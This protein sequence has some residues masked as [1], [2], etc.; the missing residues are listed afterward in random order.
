MT[1]H[2]WPIDANTVPWMGLNA[3]VFG[4]DIFQQIQV[5]KGD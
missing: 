2:W 1:T 3:R 4:R 5:K